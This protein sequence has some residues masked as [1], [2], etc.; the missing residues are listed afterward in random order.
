MTNAPNQPVVQSVL[1]NFALRMSGD[2]QFVGFA[3][4]RWFE[5]HPGWD[6][7]LLLFV[8]DMTTDQLIQLKL[9]PMPRP[10]FWSEDVTVIAA[11]TGA[12]RASLCEML[13]DSMQ[14]T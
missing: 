9:S 13:A 11:G 2:P 4:S 6:D 8:L 5:Q 14:P 3:L 7:E 12:N 1:A 10:E